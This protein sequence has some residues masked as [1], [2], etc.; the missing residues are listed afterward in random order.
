MTPHILNNPHDVQD[1]Y[2][3]QAKNALKEFFRWRKTP[4]HF[5]QLQVLFET[6]FFHITTA[7]ALYELINEG[8]LH[9]LSYKAGANNVMFL[10]P[11]RVASSHKGKRILGSHMKAKAKTIALYDSPDISKDLGAHFEALVKQELRANQLQIVS[12]HTNSYKGKQ[13]TKSRAN[14]DIIADYPDGRAF[15]IQTKNELKSIEKDELLEQLE[16]CDCLEIKPL[17]IVRYMPWGLVPFVTD[18]GGFVITLGIQMYPL[19][20]KKLCQQIQNKLSLP[21]N[22]ISKKLRDIAPKMRTKW[23]IEVSTE[24][25]EDACKRLAYWLKTGKLPP[26]SQPPVFEVPDTSL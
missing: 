23:P 21:E 14:L 15:G 11:S 19:G 18:R 12:T 24:L 10:V 26:R 9:P 25:P 1:P 2:I 4:F 7:Q 13:W 6:Q 17:F 20:H 16:I 3:Q 5:R 8:L 22:Q